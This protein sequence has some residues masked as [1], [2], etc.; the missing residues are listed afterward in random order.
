MAQLLIRN[1]PEPVKEELRERARDNG[2]SLE[3]EVRK[4]L[5]DLV[6]ASHEDPVLSW[7]GSSE[8]FR[9]HH[10]GVDLHLPERQAPRPVDFE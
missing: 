4:I 5:V 2:R 3:A 10:G 7:L 9:S 1:L 6:A 8:R